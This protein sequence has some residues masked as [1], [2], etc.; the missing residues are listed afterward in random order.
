MRITKFTSLL[1]AAVF[2]TA[3]NAAVLAT[4]GD[5]QIKDDDI[6]TQYESMTSDQRKAI[7]EDDM[8]RQNIVDSAV[9][10][11]VLYQAA[12]KAG[13]DKDAEFKNALERFQKQYLASQFMRKAVESKLKSG[14]VKKFYEENKG[15]FD[16]TQV[17][18]QHIVMQDE[19][20]A[21][22]VFKQAKSKGIKFEELAKKHSLDPTVQEN[23]GNLGCF[24]RDKMVPEFA[25]AAFNMKK[26]EVKGPVRTM[27]GFHVIKV[28]DVKAGKVPGYD[29]VE[30]RAK[31]TYRMK[32]VSELLQDLRSKSNVKLNESEVK[33]FKL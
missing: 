4:V 13:M 31:E 23:K 17:C 15:F 24:T 5:T 32:L 16:S 7:N 22:K 33:K 19:Q 26:G 20:E 6:K 27:Y 29:E 30:Q 21:E 1:L 9:N 18:A 28:T 2:S 25:A 11:E 3:A 10:G 12:K 14:D 8:T